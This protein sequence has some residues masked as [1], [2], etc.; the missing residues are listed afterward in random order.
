VLRVKK[1]FLFAAVLLPLLS[2][3]VF[4]QINVNVN[5]GG[6][7]KKSSSGPAVAA[8][9]GGGGN[10]IA[11]YVFGIDEAANGE[12]LSEAIVT[13]LSSSRKYSE[14]RRGARGFFREVEK[15]ED[16]K[17][18]LL[19]D[20]DFCRIGSDYEVDYLVIIDIE[21][22]GRGNSVWARILNLDNCRLIA[23]AEYTG[24]VRN[25]PEIRQAAKAISDELLNARIG[26]RSI[27]GGGGGAAVAASAQPAPPPSRSRGDAIAG[28]VFG[29][30]N[31]KLGEDLADAIV[32][33]LEN[34][35]KYSKPRRGARGFFR[36][37]E[38]RED[39][40]R[41]L[42]SDR[43]FCRIG[44]DYEVDYLVI[45]DIEKAGRGASTWARILDLEACQVIATGE[46]T[47][48]IR[49]DREV[50]DVANDIV[51]QLVN[52]KVGKRSIT[53]SVGR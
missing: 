49:N 51:S 50:N 22:A 13:N 25:K 38:K 16:S 21:K 31:A 14:P 36:E 4:G 9:S 33:G 28:Y 6:P 15:R 3:T 29:A 1:P 37:V 12:E 48:L 46:S 40:K 7:A 17:R 30:D 5:L 44:S 52:R 19:S 34:H 20:K 42:L 11:A 26:K 10:A 45:I 41:G 2:L 39:S 24:L 47:A 32:N 35:R 27:S 43:D 8:P 18:G 23:T 53:I